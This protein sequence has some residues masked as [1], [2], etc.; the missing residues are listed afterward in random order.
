MRAKWAASVSAMAA[1]EVAITPLG[2]LTAE[3]EVEELGG[4]VRAVRVG[5]ARSLLWSHWRRAMAACG[6]TALA[7]VAL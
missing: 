7:A 5:Q 3:M 1:F 2:C 6:A 4:R